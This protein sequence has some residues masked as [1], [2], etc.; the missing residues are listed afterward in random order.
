[1]QVYRCLSREENFHCSM[2]LA[3][4]AVFALK[5]GA[6]VVWRKQQ[7]ELLKKLKDGESVVSFLQRFLTQIDQLELKLDQISRKELGASRFSYKEGLS[8]VNEVL[9]KTGKSGEDEAPAAT[10]TVSGKSTFYAVNTVVDVVDSMTLRGNS[11]SLKVTD[12]DE[13]N[14]KL[15]DEAKEAFGKA[16]T[17]ASKAFSNPS[18]N[19]T[20]RVH[21]MSICIMAKI[22]KHMD[23]PAIALPSCKSFLNDLYSLQ[24]I[25]DSFCSLVTGKGFDKEIVR[26]VC[27]LNNLLFDVIRRVSEKE[28]FWS[29]PPIIICKEDKIIHQ[30]DPL[31]DVRVTKA[32]CSK[33]S[34]KDVLTNVNETEM[35]VAWSFGA[36]E[37]DTKLIS[38]QD[39]TTDHHGHFIVA[40]N[41]DRCIKVFND[42]GKFVRSFSALPRHQV[43]EEICSVVTDREDK[44]FVL[45]KIDKY[46]HKVDLFDKDGKLLKRFPLEEGLVCC[47]PVINDSNELFVVIENQKNDSKQ[48]TIYAYRS[49]GKP[50][51]HRG[52]RQDILMEPTDMTV[53][54]GGLLMVL[55]RNGHV[56]TFDKDGKHL[57]ERDFYHKGDSPAN[58]L[59]FHSESEHVVISSLEPGFFVNISIYD[60]RRACVHN[61]YQGGEQMTKKEQRECVPPKIALT[62][63]GNIAVLVGSVG[64]CKVVVL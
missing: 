29:W 60:K 58:A 27:Y 2:D 61:I 10:V 5:F 19:A 62:K 49:D 59:A 40:D 34:K 44:I 45:T 64:E 22:L 39:V 21:A 8:I 3:S 25:Q 37:P 13:K 51:I 31:R 56:V 54:N 11:K 6:N 55:N 23:D 63:D 47:S 12:L 33:S 9:N 57:P 1:M 38:P 46:H 35:T 14:R 42:T 20:Q 41:G 48:S 26:D 52:F 4:F 16:S 24:Q 30:I 53:A 28:V 18:L 15:V 7:K 43:D 17:E 36:E 50:I 32:L